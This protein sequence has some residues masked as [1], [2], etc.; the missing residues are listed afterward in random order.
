VS[1]LFVYQQPE[2]MRSLQAVLERQAVVAARARS[3]QEA[4]Q[5][6]NK[7]NP[8]HVIFTDTALPDGS[9]ADVL[10]LAAQAPQFS[11]VI[12]VARLL[13]TRLYIEAIEAGAFD[14][15]A[16]PFVAADLAHIVHCAVDS[17]LTRRSA[18]ARLGESLP[19]KLL[20]ASSAPI[21]ASPQGRR[22]GTQASA[23]RL[24]AKG[25]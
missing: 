18:E 20:P 14:F 19:A 22:S 1:A 16:P 4:R 24:S 3:C 15:L 7:K 2:P 21:L 25:T 5:I 8:P 6:L 9:W 10:R 23:A 12:V 13:D 11:N 17:A